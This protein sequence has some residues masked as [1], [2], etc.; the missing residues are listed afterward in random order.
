MVTNR[1][2]AIPEDQKKIESRDQQTGKDD[3]GA[4]AEAPG[5]EPFTLPERG[6]SLIARATG[7]SF[8]S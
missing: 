6:P 3:E 2:G 7:D 8:S 5:N 4:T 1:E